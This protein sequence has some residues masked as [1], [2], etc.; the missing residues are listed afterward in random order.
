MVVKFKMIEGIKCGPQHLQKVHTKAAHFHTSTPE[1]FGPATFF[2]V[3]YNAHSNKECNNLSA[4]VSVNGLKGLL[5]LN[6]WIREWINNPSIGASS[7]SSPS[8][9]VPE[10]NN[11]Q[12]WVS[13][14]NNNLQH[15]CPWVQTIIPNIY[16]Q[17][18]LTITPIISVNYCINNLK[19]WC[20]RMQ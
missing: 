15:W 16:G 11:L 1:N 4:L 6:I 19:H 14:C 2:A 18:S 9:G 10:C 8:I 7:I 5:T 12:H 17:W 3:Y 13:Q 20:Q